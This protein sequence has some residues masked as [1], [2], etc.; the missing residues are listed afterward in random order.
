[1]SQMKY[2]SAFIPLALLSP[3][4]FAQTPVTAGINSP[5]YSLTDQNGVNLTSFRPTASVHDLSIGSKDRPLLHTMLTDDGEASNPAIRFS[6][7]WYG[8]VQ[9]PMSYDTSPVCT[10]SSSFLDVNLAG[11]ADRMCGTLG[12][13]YTPQRGTGTSMVNNPDGS[14]TYLEKDG[15]QRLF[16][17]HRL[18]TKVTYPD[19]L[20]AA[21]T[22]KSATL[23]SGILVYRLQSVTRSDGLQLKYTYASNTAPTSYPLGLWAQISNLRAINNA[24]DYCDPQ[25]D[26]CSFTQ[27]WPSASQSWATSGS[28]KYMTLVD[29]G[30][31]TTRFT[32][33]IPVLSGGVYYG[34]T[35]NFFGDQLLAVRHP[36]RTS[37]DSVVYTYCAVLGEYYCMHSGVKKVTVDGLE[38]NYPATSGGGGV[39][40]YIQT[41]VSR[42]AG[43]RNANRRNSNVAITL[44]GRCASYWD[45]SACGSFYFE[46]SL[47]NR[48]QHVRL[49]DGN[50]LSYAYDSRGNITRET[51][52]PASGSTLPAIVRTASYSTTCLYQ[53]KCNKP[54][55]VRDA[56]LN[57]TDYLYSINHGGVLSVT[58]PPDDAGV[59]P[60]TRYTYTQRY[61]WYKNSS[62]TVVRA[63]TPVWL[64]TA[65][66]LCRKTA[67]LEDRSGCS[68]GAVD[69]VAMTYDY[70]P[71]SGANNLFLRG[72]AV[73][74]D[75]LTLRTC[76]GYDIYGNR[77]SETLP[78]AGLTSCP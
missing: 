39:S 27:T 13:S 24:V 30:G 40:L 10:G 56:N 49:G 65:E 33:G 21:L 8:K 78:K 66:K 5:T 48:L 38:W 47:A 50:E 14:F 2:V 22:Y 17:S 42:P 35:I 54:N 71:S 41:T 26:T 7:N 34:G 74:A 77:I 69:E 58:L 11:S 31:R 1:M 59:R 20:I 18:M 51:H 28:V 57:Q 16:G 55:W 19:G 46:S 12:G 9:S 25:A 6:D 76:Y 53:V 64:L 3:A 37:G 63:A 75:G 67:T 23:T 15:T 70:G 29:N 43:W 72:K 52:T 68:G 36:T 61:A 44:R 73:T 32:V 60:Q 62:G 45:R 4:A